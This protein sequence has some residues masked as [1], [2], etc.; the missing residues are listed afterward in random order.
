MENK[1]EHKKGTDEK[2]D[3]KSLNKSIDN[4]NKILKGDRI[5]LKDDNTQ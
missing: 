2:I 3:F 4:K 5:V 1:I